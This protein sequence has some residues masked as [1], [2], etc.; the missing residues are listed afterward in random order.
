MPAGNP[1]GGGKGTPLGPLGG[2][3]G[4]PPGGGKGMGIPF[5]RVGG[6]PRPNGGG[7]KGCRPG[8]WPSMGL[9]AD[10]PSAA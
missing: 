9:E 8:F 2:G 7:G 5:G 10:W 6:M 1:P 3:N 4:R